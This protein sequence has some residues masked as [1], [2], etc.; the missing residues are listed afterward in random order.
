MIRRTLLVSCLLAGLLCLPLVTRPDPVARSW[1]EVGLGVAQ[2]LGSLGGDAPLRWAERLYRR[3]LAAGEG[4]DPTLRARA[5]RDLAYVHYDL[6]ETDQEIA[7]YRES[8]RLHEELGDRGALAGLHNDLGRALREVGEGDRA[9]SH[10]RQALALAKETGARWE[11]AAAWNNLAFLASLEDPEEAIRLYGQAWHC[12]READPAMAA[13]VRTSMGLVYQRMGLFEDALDLYHRALREAGPPEGG[14]ER[15]AT[16]ATLTERGWTLHHL[17]RSQEA[18]ADLRRARELRGDHG[19]RQVRAGT[20]DRTGSVLRD[21]ERWAEAE[22]A[23]REALY[24]LDPGGRGDLPEDR[25]N[26][27]TNLCELY[28]DQGR[29]GPARRECGRVG[30]LL[31]GMTNRDLA[32]HHQHLLAR[33]EGDSGNLAAALVH[34]EAAG[35]EVDRRWRQA[36]S[37]MLRM[38]L[39]ASRREYLEHHLGLLMERRRREPGA[40]WDIAALE[41]MERSR[42]RSF[43]EAILRRNR[44]AAAGDGGPAGNRESDAGEA[45]VSLRRQ[46][47]RLVDTLPPPALRSP[48]QERELR[49]LRRRHEQLVA[50]QDRERQ[51]EVLAELR[52]APLEDLVEGLLGP[53]TSLL[54]FAVT[55]AE[56]Y[57]WHVTASGIEVRTL[58]GRETLEAAVLAVRGRISRVSPPDSLRIVE[59]NLQRLGEL[60]LGPVGADLRPGRLL[61]LAD[62]VIHYVPF[63]ALPVPLGNAPDPRPLV[64]DHE[65]IHVASLA[66]LQ[67]QRREGTPP[68]RRAAEHE[69]LL[70]GDPVYSSAD[71]RVATATARGK[72]SVRRGAWRRPAPPALDSVL[73]TRGRS[74]SRLPASRTEVEAIA[75]LV[76]PHRA[77]V[78]LDFDATRER[79]L[80]EMPRYPVIHLAGHGR[81][82]D[83][84]P[85]LSSLVLSQVDREGRPRQ[86]DLRVQ[87]LQ[88]LDLDADLV[89]LSACRTAVGR[90][91]RG[92]GLLGLSRAFRVA[93]ARN[94]VASLWNVHDEATARLM[95][96][97]YEGLYGEGL[98]PAAALRRAQ[99]LMAADPRWRDPHY[100]AGFQLQG[101]VPPDG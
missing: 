8:L 64:A 15:A 48:D 42:G 91:L 53:D 26:V 72:A 44:N 100:W 90:H 17:G 2:F 49:A 12:W 71:P 14:E 93:G 86:G 10:Y 75:R 27:H 43:L 94:L 73:A 47:D 95:V 67:V 3:S 1:P 56:T 98:A 65:V 29:L 51:A 24:V 60:L 79:V 18:L 85:E 61:V 21:L 69:V 41:V 82:E 5:W 66:A 81:V 50:Q 39:M 78:L 7:L 45:A 58:P 63:A 9:R 22:T 36:E 74:W 37:P 33:L 96:H 11:E 34:A 40:G 70:V 89:V 92:E 87:E 23:Y 59:G 20:L 76:G 80:S 46:M 57:L 99:S 84:V 31:N 68:R 19:S 25:A 54:A 32:A 35:D 38:T 97:F 55:D 52:V 77:E 16:A 101:E 30:D 83:D 62:D 4:L 6:G 28:L 88:R 13:R